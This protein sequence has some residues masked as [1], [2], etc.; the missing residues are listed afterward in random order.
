MTVW[1]SLNGDEE[2]FE[3]PTAPRKDDR[4]IM[5]YIGRQ[6][7]VIVKDVYVD[8]TYD[9]PAAYVTVKQAGWVQ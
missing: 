6:T 3:L 9:T 7:Y 4:F 5:R 2:R 1:I 8:L